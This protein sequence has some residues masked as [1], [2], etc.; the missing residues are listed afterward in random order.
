MSNIGVSPYYIPMFINKLIGNGFAAY[1]EVENASIFNTLHYY[2]SDT[3]RNGLS[4]YILNKYG[5]DCDEDLNEKSLVEQMEIIND[6]VNELKE[7]NQYLIEPAVTEGMPKISSPEWVSW[8]EE[9][10]ANE[11]GNINF[12]YM[13]LDGIQNIANLAIGKQIDKSFN[14]RKI[15]GAIYGAFEAERLINNSITCSDFLINYVNK[16]IDTS[17]VFRKRTASHDGCLKDIA[18][19]RNIMSEEAHSLVYITKVFRENGN[20]MLNEVNR[21]FGFESIVMDKS[22]GSKGKEIFTSLRDQLNKELFKKKL[23]EYNYVTGDISSL[24]LMNIYNKADKARL[25]DDIYYIP[26]NIK[27]LNGEDFNCE[28]RLAKQYYVLVQNGTLFTVKYSTNYD[29]CEN[30][31]SKANVNCDYYC[32]NA[33]ISPWN[34]TPREGFKIMEYNLYLNYFKEDELKQVLPDSILDKMKQSGSK[35]I[36]CLRDNFSKYE[37]FPSMPGLFNKAEE[38]KRAVEGFFLYKNEV[39]SLSNYITRTLFD[40]KEEKKKELAVKNTLLKSDIYYYNF[41][42][43]MQNDGVTDEFLTY[44]EQYESKLTNKHI[45]EMVPRLLENDWLENINNILLIPTNGN[46]SSEKIKFSEISFNNKIWNKKL[47]TSDFNTSNNVFIS[48]GSINYC[49]KKK[50]INRLTEQDLQELCNDKVAIQIDSR[51]Y[52]IKTIQGL[53]KVGI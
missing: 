36:S 42:P 29:F 49:S 27:L 9:Y 3:F 45:S 17:V 48:R 43:Y 13:V 31:F 24:I 26:F 30:Q 15:F 6:K 28:V 10:Y 35:V 1:P 8:Q 4:Q 39:E 14:N 41:K 50:M 2:C 20:S 44:Y 52:V 51:N 19:L 53:V 38:T 40:I 18:L 37:M 33:N 23:D 11:I 32:V 12:V 47:L 21:H 16:Y 25:E 34:V 22:A 46:I 5:Q 7:S